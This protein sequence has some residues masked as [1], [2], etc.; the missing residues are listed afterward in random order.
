MAETRLKKGMG[1]SP[2]I[3]LH[4]RTKVLILSP[5]NLRSEVRSHTNIYTNQS[6]R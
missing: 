6:F 4:K 5:L 3:A 2:T 1:F